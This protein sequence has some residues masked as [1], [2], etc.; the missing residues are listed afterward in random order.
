M[1][2]SVNR[3]EQIGD[4][5]NDPEIRTFSSGG[6]VANLSIATT[7]TY[8]DQDS[9]EMIDRTEWHR[10]NAFNKLAEI[11]GKYLR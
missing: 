5:G 10:V 4:L 9:G 2:R 7:F 3:V 1:A 6:Q 8:R 11:C